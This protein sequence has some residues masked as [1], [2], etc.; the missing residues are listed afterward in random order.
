MHVSDLSGK[1]TIRCV[2]GRGREMLTETALSVRC[3]VSRPGCGPEVQGAGITPPCPLR[4]PG[5]PP[6]LRGLALSGMKILQIEDV[7]R[8]A[9]D[10][11]HRKGGRRL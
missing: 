9:S 5:A 10:S 3:P 4:S 11:T 2:T 1:E 6:A 7:T 8:M